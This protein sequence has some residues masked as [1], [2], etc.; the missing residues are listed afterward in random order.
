MSFFNRESTHS[1]LFYDFDCFTMAL[2]LLR[3][4]RL[5]VLIKEERGAKH[6]SQ[7]MSC[8]CKKI[9]SIPYGNKGCSVLYRRTLPYTYR[10]LEREREGQCA[11]KILIRFK[12]Y[13]REIY[14]ASTFFKHKKVMKVSGCIFRRIYI[15]NSLNP[16]NFL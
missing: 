1:P 15:K 10:L 16:I 12:L 9:C 5:S 13:L 14:K 6:H 4:D 8:R 3:E 11:V 2:Q 7:L